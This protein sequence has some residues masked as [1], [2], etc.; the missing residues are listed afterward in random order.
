MKQVKS[1]S[2]IR[3]WNG[4]LNDHILATKE[5]TNNLN[6][7]KLLKSHLRCCDLTHLKTSLDYL[8]KLLKDEFAMICQL[9]PPLFL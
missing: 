9:G 8:E 7:D 3:M 2:W 6:L 1:T 4:K 5:I